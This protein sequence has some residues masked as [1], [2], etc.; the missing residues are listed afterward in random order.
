MFDLDS[1]SAFWLSYKG[2]YALVLYTYSGDAY[3]GIEA[4]DSPKRSIAGE[5]TGSRLGW[6]CRHGFS[7]ARCTNHHLQARAGT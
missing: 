7:V 1:K 4:R 5:Y 6:R 3:V 2:G